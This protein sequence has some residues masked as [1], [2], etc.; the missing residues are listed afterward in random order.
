MVIDPVCFDMNRQGTKD[1]ENNQL[2]AK[3]RP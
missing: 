1:A 2:L 3:Y